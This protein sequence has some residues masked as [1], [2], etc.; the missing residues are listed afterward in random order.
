VRNELDRQIED[1]ENKA[2]VYANLSHVPY[3]SQESITQKI[4][5][6]HSLWYAATAFNIITIIILLVTSGLIVPKLDRTFYFQAGSQ[7]I[8]QIKPASSASNAL[9]QTQQQKESS[10]ESKR[11][12]LSKSD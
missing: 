11:T 8:Y 5:I 12:R 9:L 6:A 4:R 2:D 1:M 10:D 7:G 3:S